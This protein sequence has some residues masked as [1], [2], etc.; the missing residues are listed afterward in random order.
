MCYLVRQQQPEPERGGVT[1][2]SGFERMRPRW[3]GATVAMVIG[4]LAIAAAVLLPPPSAAR[5]EVQERAALAPVTP[6]ATLVPTATP[7]ADQR[8]L[9]ADDGVPGTPDVAKAGA[10]PC[11]HGL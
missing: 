3:A 11:H 6:R 10:G 4:G 8:T 2:P 1:P 7:V 5:L 9:P